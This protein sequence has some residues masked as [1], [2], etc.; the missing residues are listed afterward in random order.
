MEVGLR[1]GKT[2]ERVRARNKMGIEPNPEFNLDWLP[3]GVRVYKGTSDEF[4]SDHRA[5]ASFDLIFIDGLHTFN[6][7]A[8]DILNCLEWVTQKG[9]M[10]IDDCWP[11]NAAGA[12]PRGKLNVLPSTE[13]RN[14][15]PGWW[16]DVWKAMPWLTSEW[17]NGA[18]HLV[19][20]RGSALFILWGIP[21][22]GLRERLEARISEFEGSDPS[23]IFQGDFAKCNLPST[24]LDSVLAKYRHFVATR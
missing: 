8:R 9:L 4:F 18:F 1:K 2:F 22:S 24:E 21:E 12:D 13:G 6:Q 16:G 3:K 15:D 14:T 7:V 5:D 20:E 19:G 11:R 17:R 23:I 10:V